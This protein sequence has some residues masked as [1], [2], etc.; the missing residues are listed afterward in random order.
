[1]DFWL[2]LCFIVSNRSSPGL[3]LRTLASAA[4]AT[5]TSWPLALP[6]SPLTTCGKC[7]YDPFFSCLLLF[8]AFVR[9]QRGGLEEM[10]VVGRGCEALGVSQGIETHRC[11]QRVA[12]VR[13]SSHLH[14]LVV[15]WCGLASE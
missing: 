11:Q 5:A 13:L 6:P 8:R 15:L 3:A 1:M 4:V 12:N 10:V 2:I 7:E 9:M 14:S